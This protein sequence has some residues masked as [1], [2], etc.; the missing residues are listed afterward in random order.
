M[1]LKCV[2]CNRR[3]TFYDYGLKKN[4]ECEQE[5]DL[6]SVC[7]DIVYCSEDLDVH[8]YQHQYLTENWNKF[9]KYSE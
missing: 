4:E 9:T 3:L 5:E 2:A 1:Q 6:C 7:R 8:E